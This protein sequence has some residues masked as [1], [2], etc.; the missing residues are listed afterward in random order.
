[1]SALFHGGNMA[2]LAAARVGPDVKPG[3]NG[4]GLPSELDALVEREWLATNGLGSYASS[5]IPGLHTRKYH[6]LLVAA[7]APPTHRIVLLSRTEETVCCDGQTFPIDCNEYPGVIFPRGE[8][9]LKQFE[10][11][12][13]PRWHYAAGAWKLR[14]ELRLVERQNTVVLAYTNT[15]DCAIELAVRPLLA[16]RSV[17]S[18]SYQWNGRLRVETHRKNQI[19]IPATSRTPEVFIAHDGAF[20]TSSHWYLNQ[21]Y[22][23]EERRGYSALEDLWTPGVVRFA[24]QPGQS[25]HLVC[26]AEPID[27]PQVMEVPEPVKLPDDPTLRMLTRAAEQFIVHRAATSVAGYP[28][29]EP[30]PRAQL[31]SFTGMFLVTGRFGDARDV[32]LNLAALFDR[33]LLKGEAA[34][35]SLWFI[36]AIWSYWRYTNDAEA[37]RKLFDVAMSIIIDFRAGIAAGVSIGA[38]GLITYRTGGS[39]AT[40]MNARLGEW[41]VTPRQGMAVETNALWFNAISIVAE[42]AEQ[43]GRPDVAALGEY[44]DGISASFNTHFWNAEADCCF[45]VIDGDAKDPSIR[46]NQLLAVSL[47]FAVLDASRHAAVVEVVRRDLLTPMGVR[48]LD[49]KH[50]AFRSACEGNVDARER[51][52]FNGAAHPWLLAHY[53][54]ASAKI[55]GI[56]RSRAEAAAVIEPCLQYMRHRGTGQLPEVFDADAPH[57]PGGAPASAVSVCELLRCYAEDVLGA[58]SEPSDLRPSTRVRG[59]KGTAAGRPRNEQHPSSSAR[60]VLSPRV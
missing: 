21:I 4:T 50:S 11:H 60:R 18:L 53:V 24:L 8:K 54:K 20:S 14:R 58:G 43:F 30:A 47:P 44:S 57:A 32:L 19:R 34:D 31:I 13:N 6:G 2:R 28:W 29:L 41:V 51:A 5:S 48:T 36:N 25:T 56:R 39:A 35:V 52:C 27:W 23:L 40:W 9:L 59:R 49:P 33:G 38:D 16:L 22:R 37:T 1:M 15:G 45:D 12:P 3:S 46:P 42:L 10:P 26:S 7:M 17:H 55:R